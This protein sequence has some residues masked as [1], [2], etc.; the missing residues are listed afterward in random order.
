[1]IYTVS[2]MLYLLIDTGRLIRDIKFKKDRN[3]RALSKDLGVVPCN[4]NKGAIFAHC[5]TTMVQ[6]N[7]LL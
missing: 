7:I 5:I 2:T 6:K 4:R 1:M 3:G